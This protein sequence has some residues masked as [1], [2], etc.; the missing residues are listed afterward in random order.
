MTSAILLIFFID[1][2]AVYRVSFMLAREDGP[3]D[4]FSKC[5]DHI[6]QK[7]WIGRGLHCVPC[8]SFWISIASVISMCICDPFGIGV[9]AWLLFAFGVSG[10]VLVLDKVLG[11]D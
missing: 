3:F 2:M 11:Y 6:G 10:G 5:R 7:T 9:Y 1:I 8:I 4:V